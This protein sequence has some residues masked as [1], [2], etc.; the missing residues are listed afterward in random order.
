MAVCNRRTVSSLCGVVMVLAVLDPWFVGKM[1][2]EV[3]EVS[4]EMSR[5]KT[6]FFLR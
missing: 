2:C 1:Q 6:Q 3:E 4:L 5:V